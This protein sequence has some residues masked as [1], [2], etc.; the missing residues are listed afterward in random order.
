M[1]YAPVP[2]K[3]LPLKRGNK[4]NLFYAGFRDSSEIGTAS[5]TKSLH[6]KRNSTASKFI[7][8]IYN[9]HQQVQSFIDYPEQ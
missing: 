9:L 8:D 4:N 6:G 2:E 3:L 7:N 5:L 1:L